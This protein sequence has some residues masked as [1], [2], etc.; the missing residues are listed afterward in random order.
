MNRI[1][2]LWDFSLKIYAQSGVAEQCL[3][4]QD[5]FGVDVNLLLWSL[6]LEQR[7]QQLS[8]EL[9]ARA[10]TR[11]ADWSQQAVQ[12]LR[13]LRRK[14][15][16]QFGQGDGAR[17]AVRQA[18]KAAELEAERYQQLQLEQ[19]SP[20]DCSQGLAADVL[21][22]GDNCRIYLQFRQVSPER[23]NAL[24]ALLDNYLSV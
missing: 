3:A 12:P 17:E 4:L 2:S 11:V 1:N 6:W 19:L 7:G 10:E 20:G 5:D 22:N 23:I 18:I 15:K 9:L 16:A 13:A 21:A 24:C 14:L 8:S